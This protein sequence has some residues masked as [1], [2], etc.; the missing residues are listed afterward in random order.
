M[1]IGREETDLAANSAGVAA[2]LGADGAFGLGRSG[3]L[4]MAEDL[5]VADAEEDWL[6]DVD[7]RR[8]DM[9]W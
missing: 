8:G 3:F 4:D 7:D 9:L 2:R 5:G 6:T 1:E